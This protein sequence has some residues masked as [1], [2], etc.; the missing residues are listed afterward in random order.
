[1]KSPAFFCLFGLVPLLAGCGGES[2]QRYIERI[3]ASQTPTCIGQ[4]QQQISGIDPAS[5]KS[6][7]AC[8]FDKYFAEVPVGEI[9][10]MEKNFQLQQSL[11]VM[12]PI[13]LNCYRSEIDKK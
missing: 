9:R 7:C 12:R 2:D 10:R 13:I 11:E 8:A 3:K 5:A 1:M 6:I 4:L